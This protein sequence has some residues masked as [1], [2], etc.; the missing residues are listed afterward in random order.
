MFGLNQNQTIEHMINSMS[1]AEILNL[2]AS[3]EFSIIFRKYISFFTKQQQLR[4]IEAVKIRSN[5]IV[6]DI[7]DSAM[8]LITPTEKKNETKYYNILSHL[9]FL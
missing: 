8:I 6:L 7:V 1:D 3:H 2:F 4:D 9:N 5:E